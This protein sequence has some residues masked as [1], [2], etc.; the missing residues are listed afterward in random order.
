MIRLACS[1]NLR[2]GIYTLASF[3]GKYLQ[4]SE[5]V[6]LD[7][8]CTP[9]TGSRTGQRI[10]VLRFGSLTKSFP[11]GLAPAVFFYVM[12]ISI[13]WLGLVREDTKRAL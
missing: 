6:A 7:A 5:R 10:K 12:A 13:S 9:L 11:A 3:L 4:I 2:A 1:K 8:V